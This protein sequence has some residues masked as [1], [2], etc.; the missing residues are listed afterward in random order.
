[1]K[2]KITLPLLI[3]GVIYCFVCFF[4][5]GVVIQCGIVFMHEGHFLIGRKKLIDTLV[6][7]GI[8]G[9]AAGIGSWIFAK[10]DEYKARKKPPTDLN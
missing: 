9:S 4:I 6:L 10:I 1:M 5:L 8:A 3:L 2:K 7:S